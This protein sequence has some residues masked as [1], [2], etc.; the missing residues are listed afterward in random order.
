MNLQSIRWVLIG[1]VL[2]LLVS[3][4]RAAHAGHEMFGPTPQS[5]APATAQRARITLE[6]AADTVARATGGRILDAKAVGREYRIKVLTRRGEVRVYY[7]DA[8]TGAMRE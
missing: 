8:E 6:Q 3:V 7:V 5:F 1:L 4:P 2:A